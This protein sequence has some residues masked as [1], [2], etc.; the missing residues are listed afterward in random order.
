M[1]R[2]KQVL[3]TV[4]SICKR[5]I[6]PDNR[7]VGPTPCIA[8]NKSHG[9]CSECAPPYLAEQGLSDKDI[10][11]ILSAAEPPSTFSPQPSTTHAHL[12]S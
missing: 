5:A 2:P 8:P 6:G 11:R 7:A 10:A 3:V 12:P 9:L 1:K 4:C